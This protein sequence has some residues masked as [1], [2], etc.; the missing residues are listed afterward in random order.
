M[1]FWVSGLILFALASESW[2]MFAFIL[3]YCLGGIAGPTLQ[4]IISNQVPGNEQGELQGALTSIMSIT[5]IL[6]PLLMTYIFYTFTQ[7]D[8]PVKFPGAAFMAGALVMITSLLLVLR[9]LNKV[10]ASTSKAD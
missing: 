1:S 5:N 9:P 6:G 2:M 10:A 4:G 3:P 7:P 8:A